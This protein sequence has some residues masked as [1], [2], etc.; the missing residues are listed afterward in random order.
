MPLFT[1][2]KRIENICKT[3]T[4][5]NDFFNIDNNIGHCLDNGEGKGGAGG[6]QTQA[7]KFIT[8]AE[9]R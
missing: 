3:N 4:D 5:S 7:L 1:G 6:T 2:Q 8:F 9:K